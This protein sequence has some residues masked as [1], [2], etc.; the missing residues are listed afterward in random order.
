MKTLMKHYGYRD[1]GGLGSKLEDSSV[2]YGFHYHALICILRA[3]KRFPKG[4]TVILG[5]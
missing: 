2:A 4:I 1:Q 5:L 3:G